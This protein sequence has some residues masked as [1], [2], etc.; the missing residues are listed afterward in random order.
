M[1]IETSI[2]ITPERKKRVIDAADEL[3]CTVSDVLGALMRKTRAAFRNNQALIRE[4]VKYQPRNPLK[5]FKIWHVSFEPLCYEYGVS[6][7]LVFKVS[8]SRI[9]RVAIDLFLDEILRDGLDARVSE[10][11]IATNYLQAKYEII[12]SDAKDEEFW[13]IRWDRRLRKEKKKERDKVLDKKN[14]KG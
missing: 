10:D 1:G 6:E 11:D 7:R 5:K 13:V 2:T 12:H 4:A 14:K 8:V 3:H 9:Y